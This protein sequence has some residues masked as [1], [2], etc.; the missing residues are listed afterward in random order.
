MSYFMAYTGARRGEAAALKQ[1]D[2][3]LD[4]RTA[5][6]ARAVAY[7]DTRK[8]V[9]KS[10]KTEA[11]LKKYQQSHGIQST[12]HQLRHAYAS[13]LHSANIDVKDAQYLLGHST[14][15]MTQDIY[16]DLEDKRKQQV[17]NKV[18]QY[19]KRSRKLSKVLSESDKH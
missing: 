18:N 4:T 7:S 1:K 8:P 19:V 5:R 17:H 10:P 14:I 16:T 6:V 12:T 9:L 3:D 15:A 2:I 13:M 11:G